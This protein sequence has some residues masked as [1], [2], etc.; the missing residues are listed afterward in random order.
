MECGE[1]NNPQ[2]SEITPGFYSWFLQYK[3]KLIRST[4]LKSV[5]EQAGLGC[6]PFLFTTYS[7]K[8]VNAVIKSHVGYKSHQLIEFVE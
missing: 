3:A 5:R 2:I 7:S 6:P 8:S 1:T 4:M